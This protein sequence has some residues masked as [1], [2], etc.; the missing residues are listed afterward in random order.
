MTSKEAL[1]TIGNTKTN[2]IKSEKICQPKVLYL[3][4]EERKKEIETIKQELER[5]E[6]LEKIFSDSHICEIQAKF[7]KIECSS[8]KC[9]NCPLGI[10][11]GVCLKNTFEL[12]WKLQKEI[13]S[14]KK[15]NQEL[16]EWNKKYL[17][18]LERWGYPETPIHISKYKKL[19]EENK[20]LKEE[21]ELEKFDWFIVLNNKLDKFEKAIEI[22]KEY[23]QLDLEC[24][25][26]HEI[27]MGR[28]MIVIPQEQY[29]LLK[30]VLEDDK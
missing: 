11:D 20:D 29:E 19:K 21:L 9:D 1:R 16:K 26:Y 10:G 27:R 5:L 23:I 15:E 8:E 2:H 4:K 25:T 3:V 13:P 30:E 14:L 24:N 18:E 12:K 28:E 7:N 22:L 6:A 17:S